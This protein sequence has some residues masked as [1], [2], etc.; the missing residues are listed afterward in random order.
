MSKENL[1]KLSPE[2]KKL[3]VFADSKI[4][5]STNEI[6]GKPKIMFVEILKRYFS[7][8]YV[9][10]ATIVFFAIIVIS[11]SVILFSKV[12]HPEYLEQNISPYKIDV[13]PSAAGQLIDKSP[14]WLPPE[15]IQ[16]ISKFKETGNTSLLGGTDADKLQGIYNY[17]PELNKYLQLTP[18]YLKEINGRLEFTYNAYYFNYIKKVIEKMEQPISEGG[19]GIMFK[20]LLPTI[21][22]DKL[23]DPIKTLQGHEQW[24]AD[25]WNEFAIKGAYKSLLGTDEVGN[26]IWTRTWAGTWQVIWIALV[27]ATIET[28]IGVAIGAYLGFHAYKKVDTIIMRVIEIITSIPGLIWFLLIVSFFNSP[29]SGALIIAF[30]IIGWTGPVAGARLFIIT[31]KDEEFIVASKSLGAKEARQIFSHALPAIIGKIAQSFVRRIPSVVLGISSLAFLGFYKD[32]GLN[33]NL[34]SLL[35]EANGKSDKNIWLLVLP[36]TILMSLSLSLHFIAL[37]VHDALD[38][39]VIRAK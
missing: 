14:E 28:I 6:T 32:D 16:I 23:V 17:I 20:D 39:R 15:Y 25:Q 1:F 7:N 19:L 37:G 33:A 35:I 26:D 3:L 5:K 4:R 27:V 36:T 9:V 2:Q 22:G 12:Y 18:D 24:I 10:I 29:S 11:L 30:I 38:P 21:N 13:A 31:V 8:P 34:G